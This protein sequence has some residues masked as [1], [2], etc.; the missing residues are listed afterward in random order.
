M[1]YG[2]RRVHYGVTRDRRYHQDHELQAVQQ[3]APSKRARPPTNG[4]R[5][6]A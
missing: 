5:Y 4:A 6:A 1:V 3:R 2:Q